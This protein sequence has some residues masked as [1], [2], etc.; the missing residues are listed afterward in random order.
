MAAQSLLPI[1]KWRIAMFKKRTASDRPALKPVNA[2][3]AI[4]WIKDAYGLGEPR[5][6]R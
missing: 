5:L 3:A 4:D 2:G 1:I 6:R